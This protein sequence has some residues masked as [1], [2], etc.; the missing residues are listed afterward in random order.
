LA[1]KGVVRDSLYQDTVN[2]PGSI[3]LAFRNRIRPY[4]IEY[5]CYF[6]KYERDDE[7]YLIKDFYLRGGY[8]WDKLSIDLGIHRKDY[9][10][11]YYYKQWGFF[12]TFV[13]HW[14]KIDLGV[15]PFYEYQYKPE[16][17]PNESPF[18]YFRYGLR[19]EIGMPGSEA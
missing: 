10:L 16:P 17:R 13:Y 9:E 7:K 15:S 8:Q 6:S 3:G 19:F 12:I 11:Y 1:Q 14:K 2:I 4:T 5:G 18:Y